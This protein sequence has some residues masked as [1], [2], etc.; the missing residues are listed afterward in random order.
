MSKETVGKPCQY[1]PDMICEIKT[2]T[3]AWCGFYADHCK[4]ECEKREK[5]VNNGGKR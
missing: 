3:C 2:L 1:F 4:E 5:G